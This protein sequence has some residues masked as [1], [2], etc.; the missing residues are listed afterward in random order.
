VLLVAFIDGPQGY[1]DYLDGVFDAED[2][3]WQGSLAV[4]LQ[5]GAVP[6]VIG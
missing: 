1:I 2:D 6:V 4:M 5:R 3:A